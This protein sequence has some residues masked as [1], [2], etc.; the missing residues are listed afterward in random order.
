ML[1]ILVHL[2]LKQNIVSFILFWSIAATNDLIDLMI[3]QL[4]DQSFRLQN[5]A[6]V[7][8]ARTPKY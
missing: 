2:V 7:T 5:E 1:N 8:F 4:I 6:K 3:Y